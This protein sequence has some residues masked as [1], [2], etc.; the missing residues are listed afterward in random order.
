MSDEFDPQQSKPVEYEVPAELLALFGDD[1]EHHLGPIAR[2]L[3]AAVSDEDDE[4]N[5][6]LLMQLVSTYGTDARVEPLL[7]LLDAR[8]PASKAY[9]TIRGLPFIKEGWTDPERF[10]AE[11]RAAEKVG[12]THAFTTMLAKMLD[13]MMDE[14]K[15]QLHGETPFPLLLM[16]LLNAAEPQELRVIL[17]L[18]HKNVMERHREHTRAFFSMAQSRWPDAPQVRFIDETSSG[19]GESADNGAPI[20]TQQK[21]V[22]LDAIRAIRSETSGEDYVLLDQIITILSKGI[23]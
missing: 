11:F 5:Q 12:R 2:A 19:V 18:A 15:R 14:V 3:L 16:Q 8:I 6:R 10:E 9:W 22:T 13:I 1:P 20:S 23:E 21:L 17:M 4:Q 7:A